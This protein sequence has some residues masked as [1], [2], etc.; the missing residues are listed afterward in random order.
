VVGAEE[1]SDERIVTEWTSDEREREI[2]REGRR[3]LSS[4]E[5]SE[6]NNNKIT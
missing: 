3:S 1:G 5:T 4:N 6:G 2:E